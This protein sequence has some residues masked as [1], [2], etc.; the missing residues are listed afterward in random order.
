MAE[1]ERHFTIDEANALLPEVRALLLRIQAARDRIVVG[2][3]RME[4][5]LR[6]ARTNGGGSES[7]EFIAALNEMNAGL[8][9]LVRLG[10][11]LKDVDQGL[12]DFP[13]WRGDQ[14]VLLCWRLDEDAVRYWH[15]LE[16]GFRGRQ[17]W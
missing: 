12:I 6:A 8:R 9:R 7:A 16:S 2:W 4:P 13:A 1:F 11:Q 5:V 10:I 14:E 3:E 15:D 17:P